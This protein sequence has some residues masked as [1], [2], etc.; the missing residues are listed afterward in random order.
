MLYNGGIAVGIDVTTF[1]PTTG[2]LISK[3]SSIP[4]TYLSASNVLADVTAFTTNNKF[5]GYIAN[6]LSF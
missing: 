2:D 1:Q 4:L 6:V 5:L 3:T